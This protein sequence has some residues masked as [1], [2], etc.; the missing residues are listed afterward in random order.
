[1]LARLANT[2]AQDAKVKISFDFALCIVV[3]SNMVYC[4]MRYRDVLYFAVLYI[5]CK[6]APLVFLLAP[7]TSCV[8]SGCNVRCVLYVLYCALGVM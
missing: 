2:L 8:V 6:C 4:T 7:M 5:L 1:M 3:C